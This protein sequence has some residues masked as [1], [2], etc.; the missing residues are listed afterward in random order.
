MAK[1]TQGNISQATRTVGQLRNVGFILIAISVVSRKFAD[2]LAIFSEQE[3]ISKEEIL[4]GKVKELSVFVDDI[5]KCGETPVG[6]ADKLG[7]MFSAEA[8]TK[9]VAKAKSKK[10]LTCEEVRAVLA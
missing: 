9:L 6:I 4:M 8:V 7:T 10:E 2:K 1:R 3:K 5:R